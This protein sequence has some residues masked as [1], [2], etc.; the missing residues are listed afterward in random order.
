M[1]DISAKIKYIKYHLFENDP[2]TNLFYLNY[3]ARINGIAKKKA[4]GRYKKAHRLPALIINMVACTNE[5]SE[6]MRRTTEMIVLVLR[7]I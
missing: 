6:G 1:K 4:C 7:C 5:R 2:F 3:V